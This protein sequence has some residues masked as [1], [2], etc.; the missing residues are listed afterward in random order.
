MLSLC[1]HECVFVQYT[2]EFVKTNTKTSIDLYLHFSV[3]W[4]CWVL[5]SFA[6]FDSIFV[7]FAF[8]VTT[9]DW[10]RDFTY[11]LSIFTLSFFVHFQENIETNEKKT[12]KPTTISRAKKKCY[13]TGV[14]GVHAQF[15]M[16]LCFAYDFLSVLY[17]CKTSNFRH[18]HNIDNPIKCQMSFNLN[19]TIRFLT[20]LPI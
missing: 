16:F 13:R 6:Y 8:M 1:L 19:F 12:N 14:V 4:S 5:V 18:Q 15:V 17:C 11:R 10:I 20:I 2:V 7:L 9:T 3:Q